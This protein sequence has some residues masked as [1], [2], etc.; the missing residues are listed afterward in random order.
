MDAPRFTL[1]IE[2]G[3]STDGRVTARKIVSRVDA[4]VRAFGQ[5]AEVIESKEARTKGR[6]KQQTAQI[7]ELYLENLKFD[8]FTAEFEVGN[9]SHN[10]FV[11]EFAEKV[12][13]MVLDIARAVLIGEPEPAL[14][15]H[16]VQQK[17][18]L[19]L[20]KPFIDLIP[21]QEDDSI[22]LV[23]HRNER[24]SFSSAINEK[25]R[26]FI[27]RTYKKSP[28]RKALVI[29]EFR[30]NEKG[31]ILGVVSKNLTPLIT[32]GNGRSATI[33]SSKVL[34]RMFIDSESGII[35]FNES[36]LITVN[37]LESHFEASET[38]TEMSAIG[39]SEEEA[40]DALKELMVDA[41]FLYINTEDSQL[42][43]NARKLKRRFLELV[44][45]AEEKS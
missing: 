3:P 41:Y 10:L 22:V 24:L 43:K 12:T 5:C 35:R 25:I 37:E 13:Q 34:Q 9:P 28:T 29:G 16:S 11:Q 8:S 20:L 21:S 2:G 26:P 1:R 23:K 36:A 39:E 38:Y 6:R 18:Y 17:S 30:F 14:K 42:T 45:H 40:L 15:R 27:E 44:A 4:L 31:E 33:R 7:A 32:Q 19:G